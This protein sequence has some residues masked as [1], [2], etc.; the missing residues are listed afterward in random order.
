MILELIYQDTL[1]PP[2][3]STSCITAH[4][5]L[6]DQFETILGL[7]VSNICLDWMWKRSAD[8]VPAGAIAVGFTIKFV[9]FWTLESF[10]VI[11]LK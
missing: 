5:Q 2:T 4:D 8:S 3:A 9:K 6:L 7:Q 1:T 10:V 11:D